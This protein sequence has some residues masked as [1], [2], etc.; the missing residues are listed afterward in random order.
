MLPSEPARR[1]QFDQS[2]FRNKYTVQLLLLLLGSLWRHIGKHNCSYN[3]RKGFNIYFKCFMEGPHTTVYTKEGTTHDCNQ[4][5]DN[6]R[7]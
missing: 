3:V 4:N 7:T 1:A 5:E 6:Y 2:R